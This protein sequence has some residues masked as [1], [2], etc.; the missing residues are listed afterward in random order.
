MDKLA[1]DL[2]FSLSKTSLD[3]LIGERVIDPI[4][5]IVFASLWAA[6]QITYMIGRIEMTAVWVFGKPWYHGVAFNQFWPC[7]LMTN[8][9]IFWIFTSRKF[10]YVYRIFSYFFLSGLKVFFFNH[11]YRWEKSFLRGNAEMSLFLVKFSKAIGLL[12]LLYG[13]ICGKIIYVVKLYMW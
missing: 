8:F 3:I 6:R 13:Y 11:S 7:L 9:L 12:S 1:R 4:V 5:T 10:F 2:R